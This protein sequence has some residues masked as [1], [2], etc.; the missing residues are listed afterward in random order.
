MSKK[1]SKWNI[2]NYPKQVSAK[3]RL[4]SLLEIVFNSDL[5]V[6]LIKIDKFI[7]AF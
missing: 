6:K 1:S 5:N 7:S 3:S 4:L 2:K